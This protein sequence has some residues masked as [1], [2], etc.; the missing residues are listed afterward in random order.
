MLKFIKQE[1]FDGVKDIPVQNVIIMLLQIK[2][3]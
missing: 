2:N 3:Y 1:I